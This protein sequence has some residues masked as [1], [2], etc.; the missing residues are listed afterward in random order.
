MEF[1]N[2]VNKLFEEYKLECQSGV[3]AQLNLIHQF[4]ERCESP[5]EQLFF[6]EM[7]RELHAEPILVNENKP[8]YMTHIN[9]GFGSERF[10][11]RFYTQQNIQIATKQ[12]RADFLFTLERQE[13]P[14][15]PPPNDVEHL[16][17]VV[18]IDGHDF[19]EKTR[20]QAS[21]D[22]SR[23]RQMISKGYTVFRFT[24]SDVFNNVE[25]VVGEIISFIDD[26]VQE[27]IDE[28]GP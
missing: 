9:F 20:E 17:L 28:K 21:R 2:E 8:H 3:Q 7:M 15:D 18:E 25:G 27:I 11:L 4:L 23:D 12:Y 26:R 5:I 14:F 6:L 19:H 1:V 22:K 16:R 10:I 24:G 13:W